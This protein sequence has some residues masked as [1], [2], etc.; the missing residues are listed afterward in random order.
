[1]V[2]KYKKG[3]EWWLSQLIKCLKQ[4]WWWK[5]NDLQGLGIIVK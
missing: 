1:M 5:K 2:K 4:P 3:V